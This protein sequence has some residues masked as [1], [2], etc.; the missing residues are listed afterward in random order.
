MSAETLTKLIA[1]LE[2]SKK[3]LQDNIEGIDLS[4]EYF[5]H[6]A[7]K[8]EIVLL[9]NAR[10]ELFQNKIRKD[11]LILLAKKRLRTASK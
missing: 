8:Q 2:K 5:K 10:A 7:T 3:Q 9:L 6:S 1:K 4:L 11:S